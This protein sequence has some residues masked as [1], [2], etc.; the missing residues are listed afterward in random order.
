[1]SLLSDIAWDAKGN[2]EL[3]EIIQ[4]E[5][6]ISLEDFLAVIGLSLDLVQKRSGTEFTI[7][8]QMDLG[9]ELQRKM[10]LNFA[11]SDHPIFHRFVR[12]VRGNRH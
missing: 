10:L 12:A 1:M 5:L 2:E 8:N 9:T 11:G 4:K 7:A 6:K 3:C